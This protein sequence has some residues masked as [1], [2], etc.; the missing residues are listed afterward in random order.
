MVRHY[1]ENDGKMV[2]GGIKAAAIS[3]D[4]EKV[5]RTGMGL[6]KDGNEAK[7]PSAETGVGIFVM[8][9]QNYATGALAALNNVSDYDDA[10]NV[11]KQ[12]EQCLL[13]TFEAFEKF[14]TDAF[15]ATSL[16]A[17]AVGKYVTVGTDGKWK[18]GTKDVA[19][20]YIFR[21]TVT[22]NGH[23]LALIEK[24]EVSGANAA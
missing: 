8:D 18:V 16:V 9:K 24:Q 6:V 2:F 13:D 1:I 21:G 4:T 3:A 19:S 20:L 22:D 5:Y 15:D 14:G 10:F 12:G 17:A 7:L 11:V 23:T